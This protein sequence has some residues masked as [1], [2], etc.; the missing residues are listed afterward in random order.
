MVRSGPTPVTLKERRITAPALRLHVRCETRGLRMTLRA[1]AGGSVGS[2][3][4]PTL[5]FSQFRS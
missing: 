1:R 4:H 2:A 3:E 5:G